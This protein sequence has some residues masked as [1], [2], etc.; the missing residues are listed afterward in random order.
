MAEENEGWG[1]GHIVGEL[2]KLGHSISRSSVRSILL[3]NGIEPAP[4]RLKHMPWSKFWSNASQC[5]V[6]TPTVSVY[7]GIGMHPITHQTEWTKAL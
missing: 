2:Q 1:Y 4:E 5:R 7:Q 3:E 6:D